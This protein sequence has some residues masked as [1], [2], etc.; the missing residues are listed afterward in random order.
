MKIY[1]YKAAQELLPTCFERERH[2][3]TPATKDKFMNAQNLA[4]PMWCHKN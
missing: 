4:M 2:F 1:G 3:L